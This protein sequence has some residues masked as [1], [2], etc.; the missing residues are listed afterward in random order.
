MNDDGGGALPPDVA[1]AWGLRPHP[2]KGP[3]PGLSLD[4][5]VAAAVAIADRDGLDALSMSRVA[6]DLGAA[7]MSLYRYVSAKDELVRLMID[8]AFGPSPAL[9]PGIGWREALSGWA[10]AMRAGFRRHAWVVRIPIG[11][12]PIMPNEVAWFERGLAG[13]DGSGLEEAEKASVILLVT[14]YVRALAV[15]DADIAAAI[16]RS[17]ATPDEWMSAFPR[18]LSRLIDPARF[19]ALTKFIA[20]GVFDVHDD[21]DD[22]FTF[23]LERILDG[24]EALVSTRR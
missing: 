22:E 13:L 24:I 2:G 16:A 20:A 10:W 6:A 7:T 17:G 14:G 21:P 8:A 9:P 18:M 12:L 1:A 23:G 3:K 15:T 19:P 11:G 4:R 5:I